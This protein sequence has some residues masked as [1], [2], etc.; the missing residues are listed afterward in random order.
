M[1]TGEAKTSTFNLLKSPVEFAFSAQRHIF[2]YLNKREV[3]I[4]EVLI[5][6]GLN[7][8]L[9]NKQNETHV[10]FESSVRTDQAGSILYLL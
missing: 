1:L 3:S 10:L 9:V 4:E 8:C 2:V 5:F 7:R 6:D